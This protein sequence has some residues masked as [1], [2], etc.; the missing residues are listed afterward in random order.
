MGKGAC[1]MKK[2]KKQLLLAAVIYGCSF[3]AGHGFCTVEAADPDRH[4][5]EHV[6]DLPALTIVGERKITFAGDMIQTKSTTGILGEKDSLELPYSVTT[7]S[8][9]AIQTF[10][11]PQSGV[12]D[13]LSLVPQ[14]KAFTL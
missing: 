11:S 7:V 6:Y 1:M 10:S 12:M 5:T 2:S 3:G 13:T 9:K 4:D 14:A 8:Q